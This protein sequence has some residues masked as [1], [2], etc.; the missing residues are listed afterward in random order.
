MK[1]LKSVLNERLRINKE[2]EQL[3]DEKR[4]LDKQ[5]WKLLND[6]NEVSKK[7]DLVQKQID[8]LFSQRDDLLMNH[9]AKLECRLRPS[10]AKIINSMMSCY[11]LENG[12]YKRFHYSLLTKMS[13]VRKNTLLTELSNMKLHG[14]VDSDGR[15]HWGPTNK[16]LKT[17]QLQ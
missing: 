17:M 3:R 12:K 10:Q 16:L 15:G 1:K 5:W 7:K 11:V 8:E 9:I 14:I 2:I 13:K 4:D 6:S